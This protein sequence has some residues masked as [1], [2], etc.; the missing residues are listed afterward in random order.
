[1]VK[2]DLITETEERELEFI[3]RFVKVIEGM[4]TSTISTVKGRR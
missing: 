1:M 4:V 3:R 2:I